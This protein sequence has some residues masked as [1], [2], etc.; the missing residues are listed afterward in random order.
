[1]VV[2]SNWA[3][4]LQNL[5]STLYTD[6][7]QRQSERMAIEICTGR[8]K[9]HH[10]IHYSIST[11]KRKE[12]ITPHRTNSGTQLMSDNEYCGVSSGG[13]ARMKSET[14]PLRQLLKQL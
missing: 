7:G 8:G 3:N 5:L 1:M 2:N 9:Y 11:H 6:I 12:R 13:V 4:N 14:N 10:D